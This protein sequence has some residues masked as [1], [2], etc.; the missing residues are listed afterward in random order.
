MYKFKSQPKMRVKTSEWVIM[1]DHNWIFETNN[2][3]VAKTLSKT[4][5]VE[6]LWSW[7]QTKKAIKEEA[8]KEE[9]KNVTKKDEPNKESETWRRFEDEDWKEMNIARAEY[10]DKFWKVVPVNKKNDLDWIKSKLNED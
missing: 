7:S 9:A 10:L 8:I 5:M 3:E 4:F 1:F 6:Q 2:E